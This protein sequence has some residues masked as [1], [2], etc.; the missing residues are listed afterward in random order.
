MTGGLP[1]RSASVM[2]QTSDT[3]KGSAQHATAK[4]APS[5]SFSHLLSASV[6][7]GQLRSASV[8]FGQLLS[9]IAALSAKDRA[10]PSMVGWAVRFFRSGRTKRN[11]S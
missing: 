4:S 6:S 2:E 3:A 1:L 10:R 9:S 5:L 11:S 8:S 7:F